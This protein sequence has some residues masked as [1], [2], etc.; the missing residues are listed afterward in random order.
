MKQL[1][2]GQVLTNQQ[3][4]E[5]MGIS[6]KTLKNQKEKYMEHFSIYF[7]YE[8]FTKGKSKFY[9]IIEVL[10]EY[11]P[12][13][14]G[15]KNSKQEIEKVYTEEA[16]T[17]IEKNN[18]QT[19]RSVSRDINESEKIKA[20][21]HSE[22]TTYLYTCGVMKK[23][24]GT[25]VGDYGTHGSISEKV[26]CRADK[27]NNLYYELSDELVETFDNMYE[28]HRKNVKNFEKEVFSDYQNGLLKK[29][30]ML[31]K[32]GENTYSAFVSAQKEFKSVYGFIPLKVSKYQINGFITIEK[33]RN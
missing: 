19:A 1:E 20:F 32:I 23:M 8:E 29:K 24:F 11:E 25:K 9:K 12:L 13:K 2:E 15:R 21:R 7:D 6:Y 27:G 18:L 3:V 14:K 10:G 22:S 16:L 4:A 5:F 30:E 28:K 17:S 26:W 31:E 33:G